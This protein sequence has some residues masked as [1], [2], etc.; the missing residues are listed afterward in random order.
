M[1][2]SFVPRDITGTPAANGAYYATPTGLQ[3]ID[4]VLPS[5]EKSKSFLE[6]AADTIAKIF[7]GK[8]A[9]RTERARIE[10]TL[11]LQKLRADVRSSSLAPSGGFPS[12]IYKKIPEDFGK[13][14]P[15]IAIAG[16]GVILLTKKK[17]KRR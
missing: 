1:F 17:P 2:G 15:Y 7:L 8:E 6:T 11:E 5:P 9:E 4:A 10:S 16:F 3:R 12:Y 13:Y 14:L